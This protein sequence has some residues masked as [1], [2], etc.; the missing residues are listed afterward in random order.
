M[1]EWELTAAG[2]AEV[3][4]HD[5]LNYVLDGELYVKSGGVEV[6]GRRGDLIKVS[7]GSVGEYWAP[8]YA[9]M[10]AVYGPHDGSLGESRIIDYWEIDLR[11][12]DD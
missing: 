11:G 6:I 12:D 3:H 1:T 4:P 7:A 5:E 8:V 2:H 9:R 10:L